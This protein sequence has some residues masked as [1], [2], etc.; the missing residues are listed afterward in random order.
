MPTAYTPGLK[1]SACT[2]IRKERR[3]PLKGEVVVREGDAVQ[4]DT[5]VARTAIPG[6]MQTFR[7]ASLLGI[8]PGALPSVMCV[9][10][11]EKVEKGD[12]IAE[13]HGLFGRFFRNRFYAPVS[14]KVELISP[15]TG[16]VGIR[17]PS[18]P[19]EQ[20][21]YIRGVVERVLPQEGAIVRCAGALVQGIFGVGGERLG[22]LKVLVSGPDVVLDEM[23]FSE[24]H[25]GRVVV[26]GS[27]VRYEALRKA[28]EVGVV[29]IVCGGIVDTDL[30][31]LLSELLQEPN[32]EIGVATTGQEPI[33]LTIIL[34]E[35]FGYIPMAERTFRLL[36]QLEG[37][38]ASINGA[39]Q[40][41]AGVIR[42]EVVVPRQDIAPQEETSW[43]SGSLSIGTLIRLIRAPYF[44][45]IGEVLELP[46]A[47]EP[48]ESGAVVRVLRA[49]LEDGQVVTVPRA[50]VEII[51]VD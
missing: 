18:L 42:P 51:E 36:C 35:G 49:K 26:G 28:V 8:E 30:I 31:R 11:G 20:R 45:K 24:M 1:V 25:R 9:Q 3:L 40:I 50:N 34:T 46:I 22:A 33:P 6:P 2:V 5:V 13:T 39:T 15:T 43:A 48:V 32:Y 29:G 12:L 21:A 19:V 4:P 47:P 16:N 38:Q 23:H 17:L 41:R 27:G 44:G 14:G 10:L 7:V 37:E